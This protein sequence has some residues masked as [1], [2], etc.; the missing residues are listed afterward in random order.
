MSAVRIAYTTLFSTINSVPK[1]WCACLLLGENKLK[2][3]SVLESIVTLQTQHAACLPLHQL[4][5]QVHQQVQ[6]L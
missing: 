4:P 1:N 2:V 5:S 3:R 6:P